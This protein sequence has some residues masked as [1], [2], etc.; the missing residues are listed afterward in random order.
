MGAVLAFQ[1]PVVGFLVTGFVLWR[2]PRGRRIGRWLL[3][4]S[5]LTLVLVYC[6]FQAVLPGAAL[7]VT[8]SAG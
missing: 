1:T 8:N 3:S 2:R 6:L 4:A 7:H 5:P